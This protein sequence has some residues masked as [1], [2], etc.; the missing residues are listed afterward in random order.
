MVISKLR[1][2]ASST[3]RR[4]RGAVSQHGKASHWA[5]AMALSSLVSAVSIAAPAMAEPAS[6]P[7]FDPK[8]TEK[9]FDDIQSQASRSS[10]SQLQMP[11]LGRPE[12][13]A[14]GKRCSG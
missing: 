1:M 14:D 10:R 6:Q 11:H 7:G 3:W 2:V 12:S 13:A 9:Y 8:Q 4:G 5:R